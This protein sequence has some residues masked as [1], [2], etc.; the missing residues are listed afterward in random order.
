MKDFNPNT[1][2]EKNA[3]KFE[4]PVNKLATLYRSAVVILAE[5]TK[6]RG[7][8]L[9]HWQKDENI[10]FPTLKANKIDFFILKVT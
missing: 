4:L 2:L 9:S 5:E 8:D 10:D 1:R 7:L 6:I 3:D